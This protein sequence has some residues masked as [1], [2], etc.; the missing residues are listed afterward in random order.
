METE[1]EGAGRP[2]AVPGDGVGRLA[3]VSE[4]LL[5]DGSRLLLAAAA[6]V[7]VFGL[8][9][10]G[11][12][13]GV[14]AFDDGGPVSRLAS[15]LTA[16]VFSLTTIVVSINQLI[17]SREFTT[18]GEIRDRLEGVVSFHEDVEDATGVTTTPA[19]PTELLDL[20]T[21]AVDDRARA[22]RRLAEEHPDGGFRA[23]ATAV[24]DDIV[25]GASRLDGSLRPRDVGAFSALSATMRY[26]D[27][28]QL[29]AVRRLRNHHAA[30]ASPP[31]DE[32]LQELQETLELFGVAREHFKTTYMQR[33][34]TR[35]SRII[36]VTG[37]LGL[38]AA[39]LL[40]LLYGDA[41]GATVR[42]AH[43]PVVASALVAVAGFPLA[44]LATYI[45]RTAT[46]IRRTVTVGP[47]VADV[48]SGDDIDDG[49]PGS[50]R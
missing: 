45:L 21:S 47:T 16:G 12:A 30:A 14:V 15:G 44:L 10:G 38:L 29:Y 7:A 20:L 22:V 33:E 6:T 5:V 19:E 24:A 27:H 34:L 3:A 18:P 50:E 11:E 43:L 23:R 32:A 48:G 36:V 46:V 2:L 35:V 39:V 26:D 8:L 9:V 31:M 42:T 40:A 28:R 13:L 41:F 37:A 49:A 1:T 4:W 17:L 25:D